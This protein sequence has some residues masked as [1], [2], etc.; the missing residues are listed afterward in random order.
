MNFRDLRQIPVQRHLLLIALVICV[1]IQICGIAFLSQGH[2]NLDTQEYLSISKSMVE[3]NGYGVV[4]ASF[5]GFDTFQ[6]ESPTRMRQPGYPFYL[7]LF[8]WLPGPSDLVVQISQ[9]ILNLLTLVIAYRIALGVY[10]ERSRNV[11]LLLLA[12]YFPLWVT[13]AFILT[14]SLFTFL[15]VCT[16]Y[17]LWR[18]TTTQSKLRY[19]GAT[20]V[21]FA[22]MLLTRPIAMLPCLLCLAPLWAHLGFRKSVRWWGLQAAVCLVLVA[23]W[24][25]RNAV[26]LGDYT[27]LSSDG[28]YNLWYSS[29]PD[30]APKWFDSPQFIEAVGDGY[31]LDRA[32]DQRFTQIARAN[33][34]DD[35][36]DYAKRALIRPFWTW[37]YFPG[38][39]QYRDLTA[40]FMALN[41]VHYAILLLAA[42]GITATSRRN[43]TYLLLPVVSLSIVLMLSKGISRFIVPAM[44]FVL[45]LAGQGI[46]RIGRL[47]RRRT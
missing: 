43:L 15:L 41:V 35:P 36:V 46:D 14:E 4:G 42:V 38:S 24:F 33:I 31:Y 29:V 17:L 18:A 40:P 2:G 28:G 6:G 25:I 23:P 9:I 30:S 10:G 21:G 20:G 12:A 22:A 26:S 44:P 32:A 27:P 34:M 8:Y 13:S 5:A 1:I 37:S 39:R 3:G 7:V 11:T 16:M 19:F 47:A 45:I